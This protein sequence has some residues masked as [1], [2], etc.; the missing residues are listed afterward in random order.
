VYSLLWGASVPVQ[1]LSQVGCQ[2]H[3]YDTSQAAGAVNYFTDDKL[4]LT[5]NGEWRIMRAASG[6]HVFLTDK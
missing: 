3:Q 5:A 2:R 1:A 6:H 4:Q